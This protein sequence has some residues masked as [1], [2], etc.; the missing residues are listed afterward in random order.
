[1]DVVLSTALMT[2]KLKRLEGP[3]MLPLTQDLIKLKKHVDS[4]IRSTAQKLS[5]D[6]SYSLWR[7]LLQL[8][9][10]VITTFNKRRGGEVS[11]LLLDSYVDRPDWS[12]I[13]NQDVVSSLR[14]ID[15]TLINR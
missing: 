11:K 4:S 14:E 2:L 5:R 6:P 12:R 15:K 3:E 13:A 9:L 8:T 7:Q 1:M 10:A